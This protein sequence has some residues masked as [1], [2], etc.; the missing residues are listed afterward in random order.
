MFDLQR[1]SGAILATLIVGEFAVALEFMVPGA[2]SAGFKP[3]LYVATEMVAALAGLLAAYLV[4][5]RFRQSARLD[6]LLLACGLAIASVCDLVYGALAA[7]LDRA[8][9][10]FDSWALVSGHLL[11][12]AVVACSAFAPARTLKRPKRAAWLLLVYSFVALAMIAET[13]TGTIRETLYGTGAPAGHDVSLVLQ[14]ALTVIFAAASVGFF[15]RAD[16]EGDAFMAWLGIAAALRVFAGIDYAFRPTIETGWVYT[17]DLFRLLFY[18][19]LVAG[20]ASEIGRYWLASRE[21][22]VLDER[23]RIAR[24]LH[25]GLAQELSFIVGRAAHEL[26]KDPR[27]AN[28]RQIAS[29]AERALDESRRVIATLT[30]PLDEPLEVVL[31]RAVKD[32]ADRVGTIAALAI[33]SGVEVT[34]DVREALVRIAREAVT[35]AARHGRAGLVRVELENGNGNGNGVQLRIADDGSGFDVGAPTHRSDGGFGLVSMSERAQAIGAAF[36][37][38]SRRGAGTTVEVRLP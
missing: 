36:R 34:P 21:A 3:A 31:A 4:F 16:R 26:D 14:L 29:A 35:N 2:H 28:T 33:D 10:R 38:E 37:V 7:G 17:G 18:F 5:F 8:P 24:E 25:D 32:V 27:S 9:N 11:G 23:R 12:A 15:R 1:P 19:A 30:R 13:L 20:A 6:Y 22:A